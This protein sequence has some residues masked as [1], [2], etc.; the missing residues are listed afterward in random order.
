VSPEQYRFF[1]LDGCE[2]HIHICFVKYCISHR[3]VTYCQRHGQ[4][5][6]RLTR[7]GNVA[8]NKRN[9][10]PLLAK[11]RAQVHTKHNILGEWRGSGIIPPNPR[12]VLTKLPTYRD[13]EKESKPASPP[14]VLP[15]PRNS[16]AMVCKARQAKLLLQQK[17]Q[18]IDRVELAELIDSL[19]RFALNTDKDLQLERS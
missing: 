18:D 2:I 3:I 10:L 6:D 7:F 15:T 8:I 16:A 5:V 14:P 12:K 4:D 17:D 1:I 13:P 19:E 11:A 9:F